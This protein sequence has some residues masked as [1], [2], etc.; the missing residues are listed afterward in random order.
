MQ[1]L[2]GG[3][4]QW[5][6]CWCIEVAQA[7]DLV[8]QPRRLN[9]TIEVEADASGDDTENIQCALDAATDGGYRDVLLTSPDY[10]IGA[11]AATGF[12]WR[13]ARPKQSKYN[14]CDS[15]LLARLRWCYGRSNGISSG[16]SVRAKYDVIC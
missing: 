14:S 11:I 15:G 10:S 3:S 1:I 16:D 8:L 5:H 7:Q 4:F 9:G 6:F 2:W 12:R 13:S